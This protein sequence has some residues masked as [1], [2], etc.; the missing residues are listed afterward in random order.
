M[1]I[2]ILED[3][4][5][6]LE[7]IQQTLHDGGVEGSFIAVRN[8]QEFLA[9]LQ[10]SIPDVIL[11]DY[12]LPAFDGG[13]ALALKNRTC[14]EVPFILVSGVLGEEQ[15][16]EAL[17][18]GATDYVL[19]QRMGRL[20]PS[21][22]RALRETQ[23]RQ[24]RQQA[25]QALRETDDLLRAIVN[26]S[27]VGII[28][29]TRQQQVITW[30]AAATNLYGYTA[31]QVVGQPLPLIPA[32]YQSL[33]EQ[34]FEQ[35]L[36]N[37]TIV[38]QELEHCTQSGDRIDVSVSLAPLHDANDYVYGIVMT[39]NDI[40]LRKQVERQ[41]LTLLQQESAAR[42]AAETANRLKDEFLA[43][44]SH[45]LRTP[46]NAIVGWT[47]LI[48]KG[49]LNPDT[50]Q[51][52]L[53]TIARNAAA[54]TQ[55]IED[56]LDLSRIMRG[57]ISLQIESVDVASLL[58]TTVDTL[59]PAA[60]A[61]SIQINLDIAAEV[62]T[63]PADL[64][65]LQQICWNLLSN[66]IKFTPANGQV[67]VRTFTDQGNLHI[68]VVDS[69]IGIAPDFLPYVFEHF[70]QADGSATRSHGGLGLGLAIC[71]RLVELHGGTIHVD[72]DGLGQGATF[73][74]V[75]PLRTT[76]QSSV[77]SSSHI[78]GME[79]SLEGIKAI[80][81]DDEADARE[82]L[83][84]TLEQWGIQVACANNAANAYEVLK[85]FK[86]D[87][88]ISD[89]GIPDED[90]YSFLRKVRA[91]PDM[92][93]ARVPAIALTAYAREEDRQNALAVGYEEHIPKPFDPAEV[94]DAVRELTKVR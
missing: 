42:A 20:V 89:I 58:L 78:S 6:D 39:A 28:T 53:D 31:E 37:L 46:L 88:I 45:E 24:Q 2:L 71:R 10:Q 60:E 8:Q 55:L 72:S 22:K 91:W 5:I 36:Q 51:R 80:V 44:L 16:I 63:L 49:N 34:C 21:V 7:L 38:N 50:F 67:W 62:D 12:V 73:T 47:H 32:A 29:M 82:L 13:L 81:L 66:A 83:K 26:A 18:N 35:V 74:V 64:N 3:D 11:A 94:I 84:L 75:L 25:A 9:Q 87:I 56:L 54:Q 40:T 48:K 57:Q 27:P 17:K 76:R 52:A 59:R 33:F 77:P 15:A 79:P 86:P 90:G 43:V 61:K 65:R 1:Q 92:R 41:R 30:N 70:R 14:P 85:T 19:K 93:L 23:E 69:G 4:P 68:E